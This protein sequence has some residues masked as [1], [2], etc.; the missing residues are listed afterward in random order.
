MQKVTSLLSYPL[1]Q[2]ITLHQSS[3]WSLSSCLTI[4]ESESPK[5]SGFHL[6]I[7]SSRHGKREMRRGKVM[8]MKVRKKSQDSYIL[9]YPLLE[10]VF[11]SCLN[12]II[13]I[14]PRLHVKYAITYELFWWYVIHSYPTHSL[15]IT[16][17]QYSQSSRESLR[18]WSVKN[19]WK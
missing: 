2:I 9:D 4:S 5:G 16:M 3:S 12:I 17:I 1:L 14:V 13:R 19:G 18:G 10:W 11:C 15:M 8:R 7:I 6:I